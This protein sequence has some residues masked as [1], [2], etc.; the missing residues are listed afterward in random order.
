MNGLLTSSR[1]KDARACRRKHQ[2][3]Y[4]LGFV[5]AIEAVVLR[6][7]TLIHKGLEAWWLAKQ[8]GLPQEAWLDAALAATIGEA[9]PYDRARAQVLLTGYHFRWKDEPYE[10]L[11]VEA[12]FETELVNPETGHPSRTW[13]L[14]GKIDVVVRDLRTGLVMLVEHKT[15][16]EDIS[17]G[18]DYYKRLRLDGQVSIYFEGGRALGYDV[19]ACIYD[20]IGKPRHRP[21]EANSR[22]A[23]AETPDEFRER[24][25][26][27]VAEEPA[28]HFQRVEVVRLEQEMKDALLDVWQLGQQL[29]EE[30]LAQRFPRNPDACTLYHRTCEYWPVCTGE[31]SL[32]DTRLYVRLDDVHPE[33]AGPAIEATPKEVGSP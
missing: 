32:D 1:A 25:A 15:S 17:P 7:G 28:K 9:D 21:L 6:F 18:S 10:V 2:L 22:R 27:A 14:G 30:Q 20:V 12:R 8:A 19:A 5:S 4:V 31:A 23:V 13:R 16:A 3:R 33:L 26:A 29:R 11:A 24:L